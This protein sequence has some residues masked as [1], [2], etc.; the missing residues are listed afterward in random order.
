MLRFTYRAS[1]TLNSTL[2][3][4]LVFHIKSRSYESPEDIRDLILV[5]LSSMIALYYFTWV[6]IVLSNYLGK[7]TIGPGQIVSIELADG[8]YLP[9]YLGYFFVALSIPNIQTFFVVYIILTVFTYYSQ[10]LYFNPMFLLFGYSFY[11]ATTDEGVVIFIVSDKEFRRPVDVEILQSA[12][13]N[14]F[15]FIDKDAHTENG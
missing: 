5:T 12:R 6:N 7:D 14:G 8:S 2:L 3:L 1:L 11:K 10:S 4:P 9:S 13:I 15:T